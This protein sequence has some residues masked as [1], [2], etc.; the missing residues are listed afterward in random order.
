[1]N[2]RRYFYV[3]FLLLF[4]GCAGGR[5][6]GDTEEQKLW[7]QITVDLEAWSVGPSFGEEFWLYLDELAGQ[8]GFVDGRAFVQPIDEISYELIY[9]WVLVQR[10]SDIFEPTRV[11]FPFGERR[12]AW[13]D[14]RLAIRV[15]R[16][17][18]DSS[19]H[20]FELPYDDML[21]IELSA[22]SPD[23]ERPDQ[24]A[25]LVLLGRAI[26]HDIFV[27]GEFEWA[28]PANPADKTDDIQIYPWISFRAQM[29]CESGTIYLIALPISAGDG[30]AYR[31]DVGERRVLLIVR[32]V[33]AASPEE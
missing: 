3:A 15:Y 17:P 23:P 1:M 6:G 22:T 7:P 25:H 16:V 19:G 8:P 28:Q 27:N 20:Q 2:H 30:G 11:T 24:M 5:M 12:T 33:L 32:P 26:P 10:N 18:P 21:T 31:D 4:T 29:A 13:F 9:T 14:R